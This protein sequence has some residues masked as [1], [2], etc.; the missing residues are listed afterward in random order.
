MKIFTNIKLFALVA[1]LIIGS[2]A[3]GQITERGTAT[4]ATSTSATVTINKPTGLAV[5]DV[6]LANIV[7]A[8]NNDAQTLSDATRSGWIFVKGGQFAVNGNSSWWGTVLYKV[9]TATD[10][11]ATNFA[12][13]LDADADATVGGIVAYYNVSATGVG[14][15]GTGTGPFDVAAG[16]FQVTGNTASTTVTAPGITTAT[17]N[18]AVIMMGMV[19]NNADFSGWT[20][21]SPGALT[22]V[23]DINSGNNP[24]EGA[25]AA[26]ALKASA[27]ATGNGTATISSN[28]NGGLLIA[29]RPYI[30]PPTATISPTGTKYILVGGSVSFT[31]TAGGTY[32]GSGNYTYTWIAPGATIPGANP[33]SIAATSDAK[34]LTYAA[35]GTY[36]VKVTISRGTTTITTSTTTVIVAA[37]PAV[38]NMWASASS[39]TTIAGYIVVNGIYVSGP[40]NIFTMTFPGTTTGGTTSAA[41]GKNDQGGPL[42]GYFYWLPNTSGNGGVVEIFAATSTGATPTRVGSADLNGSNTNSL[43]FVRLGIGPDGYGWILAG[44]AT[45]LYLAKFL[46]SGVNPVTVTTV[47]LILSGG[48]VSTFQNGDVCV[49]GD[50]KLYALANDGSGVTQIFI[51]SLN[52]PTVTLTKKWDLVDAANAPFTG[53]VNGVAF[54]AIGSLYIT[55]AAGLYFIDQATVNN[56]GAGTVQCTLVDSE[57]GLQDLGSA[58]YPSGSTLPVTLVNFLGSYNNNKTSLMWETENM[59]NFS[60]FEIERSSTASNFATVGIK[61]TSGNGMSRTAY[62]YVDDLTGVSGSVFYYRLKMVDIDGHFKYSNIVAIRKDK[63]ASDLI[64]NPNPVIAGTNKATANFTVTSNT[65]VI[66]NVID[67]SGKVVLTQQNTVSQGNN[68]VT[69]NNLDRLQ[70]G[71][72]M[73][74][75]NDGETRTTTKFYVAH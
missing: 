65:K 24:D 38:P 11:A 28:R 37:A 33:N 1:G 16:T 29:L 7:Q 56:A 62:Q 55:T 43:G 6:M 23:I 8:D 66:F 51:G 64:I 5:G 61:N 46:T 27:G 30:P 68:S 15:D 4:T 14:P 26:W 12:F 40:T 44:D 71:M 42:N 21:T 32:T 50:N 35:A 9:A 22:E 2:T 18:A 47:P 54:D 3:M 57:T 20:T 39:G 72:Y 25:G 73:L 13:T 31:A 49:L 69:I 67:M 75:M 48:L 63:K 53:S 58:W 74:Q 19:A 60:H 52:N 45:N 59:M 41:I 10:V 34:N 17:A 36:T 70:S